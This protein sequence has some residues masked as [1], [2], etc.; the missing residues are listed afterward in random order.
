MVGGADVKD[1]YHGQNF[2][3]DDNGNNV[4]QTDYGAGGGCN[5]CRT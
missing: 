1:M 2:E 3:V 5:M 4:D